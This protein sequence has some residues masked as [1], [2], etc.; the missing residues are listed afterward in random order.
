MPSQP[1]DA[2]A[3]R[4]VIGIWQY[5]PSPMVSRHLALMGWDWV[6][7]DMQHCAIGTETAYECIHT[8]RL[9]GVRPVV[10][11]GIGNPFEVQRAL[12]LGAGGVV[13]P[14]VNSPAEAKAM[15]DAA[16]YPPLG[17]RSV[18]GDAAYHYGPDY[19]DRAN[20]ETLL[21]VQVEHID[22]VR[23]IDETL[24]LPGVDGVFLGPTDLA[25]S[26]GLGHRDYDAHPDHRAAIQRTL[27]AGRARGKLVAVNTYSPDDAAEKLARGFGCVT[28][29]SDLDLFARSGNALIGQLRASAGGVT[30]R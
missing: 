11:V 6:I 13:V 1:D 25:L 20:A 4:P 16:K 26:M 29:M 27:D 2:R 19:V 3:A 21:L 28:M 24:A 9:G 8:L 15:A 10:R 23:S 14:M 18:G 17:A 5:I 7:L 12:D 22:A 30:A